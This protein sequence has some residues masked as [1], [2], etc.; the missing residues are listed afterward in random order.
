MISHNHYD[1]CDIPTLKDVYRKHADRP[2]YLFI[3]LAN[4]HTL[5][6][7]VPSD[8]VIEMDWWDERIIEVA[9]KGKAKVTCSESPAVIFQHEDPTGANA[10]SSL[11]AFLRQDSVRQESRALVI[12]DYPG[13]RRR[14]KDQG[15]GKSVLLFVVGLR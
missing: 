4:G 12:M 5:K 8:R 2:P 11:S 15:V 1:H 10:H 13:D 3:P 14:W 7:T 9:G 6:G